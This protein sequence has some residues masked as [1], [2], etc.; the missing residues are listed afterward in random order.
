MDGEVNVVLNENEG[1]PCI[2]VPWKV[3]CDHGFTDEHSV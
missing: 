1:S 2:P 3:T